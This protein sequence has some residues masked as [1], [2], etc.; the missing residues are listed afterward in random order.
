MDG[1][2]GDP[3][4]VADGNTGKGSGLGQTDPYVR[5]PG[6]RAGFRGRGLGGPA[7]WKRRT[8]LLGEVWGAPWAQLRSGPAEQ[9]I[10][11]PQRG[12]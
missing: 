11:R 12:A 10:S 7:G 2:I 3:T 8:H 6:L 5:K 1:L 9:E 4:L